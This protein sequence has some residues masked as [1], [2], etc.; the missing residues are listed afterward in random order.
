[1]A[2]A[3]QHNVLG[4]FQRYSMPHGHIDRFLRLLCRTD[5]EPPYPARLAFK[6]H[7]VVVGRLY[8]CLESS[9]D[10]I[11]EKPV[12]TKQL[13]SDSDGRCPEQDS[14]VRCQ[15]KPL[16][17]QHPIPI[18]KRNVGR[19]LWLGLFKLLEEGQQAIHLTERQETR[20]VRVCH[21]DSMIVL[22]DHFQLSVQ[23]D[24]RRQGVVGI[25]DEADVDPP[26]QPQ[27]CFRCFRCFPLALATRANEAFTLQRPIFQILHYQLLF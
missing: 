20:D 3:H 7:C 23:N 9:L 5:S 2:A 17:V 21:L 10:A 15:A 19:K 1:M 22:V 14:E 27:R 26:E 11:A 6:L 13:L 8:H 18:N 4:R 16:I 24:Q 12:D 25:L